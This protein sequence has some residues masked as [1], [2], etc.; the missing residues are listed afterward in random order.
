MGANTYGMTFVYLQLSRETPARHDKAVGRSE[1]PGVPV[2]I[3]CIICPPPAPPGTTPLK[4][5]GHELTVISRLL[6]LVAIYNAWSEMILKL[7]PGQ[8]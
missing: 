5:K 3:V 2:V 4:F 8:N 6:D 1:N 7:Q